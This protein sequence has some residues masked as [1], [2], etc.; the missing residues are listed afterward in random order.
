MRDTLGLLFGKKKTSMSSHSTPCRVGKPSSSPGTGKRL[1]WWLGLAAAEVLRVTL[2]EG[3]A[4]PVGHT[5][6]SWGGTRGQE[7]TANKVTTEVVAKEEGEE[8][9]VLVERGS[10]MAEAEQPEQL[11]ARKRRTMMPPPHAR[12]TAD[13]ACQCVIS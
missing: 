11:H 2:A 6:F 10:K 4:T 5:E 13:A 3:D 1:S 7:A 8:D 12:V 9:F